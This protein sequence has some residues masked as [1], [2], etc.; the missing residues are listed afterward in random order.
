M[1]ATGRVPNTKGLGLEDMGIETFRGF[2]QVG[3]PC[4]HALYAA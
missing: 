4:W 2:V 1:V 3:R